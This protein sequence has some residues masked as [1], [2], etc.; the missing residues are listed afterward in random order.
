MGNSR[1]AG[2]SSKEIVE[3]TAETVEIVETVET[4]EPTETVVEQ[5]RHY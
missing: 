2:N 1:T 3:E 5:Q 4:T